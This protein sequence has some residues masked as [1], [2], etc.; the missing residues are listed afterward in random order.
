M[1]S[2]KSLDRTTWRGIHLGL[3]FFLSL[4]TAQGCKSST[5]EAGSQD[6]GSAQAEIQTPQETDGQTQPADA[7]AQEVASAEE[8]AR[9]TGIQAD[10]ERLFARAV[11]KAPLGRDVS[12]ARQAAANRAR[13]R[14]AKL[15]KEKGI[16]SQALGLLRG[17]S[18]EKFYTRGRFV[19]AVGVVDI[20]DRKEEL[21]VDASAPSNPTVQAQPGKTAT[22]PNGG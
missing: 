2:Y 4:A 7:G 15:L 13:A 8:Q 19:Y 10:G 18:I 21:N 3:V 12:L 20:T 9:Q 14:L 11:G 22:S 1:N 5:E 17:A 16:I 6:A